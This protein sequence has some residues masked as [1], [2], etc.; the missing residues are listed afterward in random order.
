MA[1]KM[2]MK[3]RHF[4]IGERVFNC[5]YKHSDN[6]DFGVISQINGKPESQVVGV[7]DVVRIVINDRVVETKGSNVYKI[8][9]RISKQVGE[10]VCYEHNVFERG[11][12]YPFYLTRNYENYYRFELTLAWRKTNFKDNL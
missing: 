7:D 12:N 2:K 11:H 6:F 4:K 3:H 8:A 5:D 10:V 9:P 1:K